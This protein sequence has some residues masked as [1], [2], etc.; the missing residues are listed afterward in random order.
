MADRAQ[1]TPEAEAEALAAAEVE[2]KAVE[3]EVLAEVGV[4][5]A[6][7]AEEAPGSGP[8]SQN[9]FK[10]FLITYCNETGTGQLDSQSH[11]KAIPY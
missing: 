11:E 3:V 9:G 10:A 4:D 6:E 2:V 7:A 1:A 5:Q 8:N